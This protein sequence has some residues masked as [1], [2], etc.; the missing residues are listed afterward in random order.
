MNTFSMEEFKKYTEIAFAVFLVSTVFSFF[1]PKKPEQPAKQE[2]T[3][4]TDK[5]QNGPVIIQTKAPEQETVTEV[6]YKAHTY[7]TYTCE[8]GYFC[9]EVPERWDHVSEDDTEY[10]YVKEKGSFLSVDFFLADEET[11]LS[12]E[13][14]NQYFDSLE[15]IMEKEGDSY[16]VFD[17]KKPIRIGNYPGKVMTGKFINQS[18]EYNG[19]VLEFMNEYGYAFI[20]FIDLD[21]KTDFSEVTDHIFSSI[22]FYSPEVTQEEAEKEIESLQEETVEVPE[23][24]VTE[25][26]KVDIAKMI[27]DLKKDS[28]QAED[29]YLGQYLEIT[30][31]LRSIDASGDYISIKKPNSIFEYYDV[32]CFIESETQRKQVMNMEKGDTVTVKGKCTWVGS[33]LGY[34][35]HIDEIAGYDSVDKAQTVYNKNEYLECTADDLVDDLDQNA[36]RAKEKYEGQNLKITGK[37]STFDSDGEYFCIE[38][39][40]NL[41]NLTFIF[42]YIKDEETKKALQS[43]DEDDMITFTGRCT[44]VGE[45]LGYSIDIEKIE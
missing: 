3:T 19:M 5:K 27:E 1:S 29:K 22:T 33:I 23:Q 43:Y 32:Q 8:D 38:P 12:E 31:E 44:M 30:G 11:D 24:T 28:D 7:T 16:Y 6:P 25:Y 45:V 10:Y 14:V 21:E 37:I 42:C 17:T 18:Y 15:K 4:V 39:E 9:Y 13:S 34:M 35:L 20:Q 36:L 41:F 26:T 40:D 2:E